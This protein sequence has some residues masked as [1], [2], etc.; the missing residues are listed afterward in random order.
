[1][2]DQWMRDQSK[3]VNFIDRDVSDATNVTDQSLSG[4]ADLKPIP[5]YQTI[6]NDNQ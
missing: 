1:M 3:K 5:R 4:Q 2:V 6:S